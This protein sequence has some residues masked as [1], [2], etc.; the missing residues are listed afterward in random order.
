M[1]VGNQFPE[2]IVTHEIHF[3]LGFRLCGK[4]FPRAFRAAAVVQRLLGHGH[5]IYP[6]LF[7]DICASAHQTSL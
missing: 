1:S 2:G 4:G 7:F 5:A 6:G 3:I